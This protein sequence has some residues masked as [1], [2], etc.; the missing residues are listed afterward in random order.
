MLTS[1]HT[2]T[3][4]FCCLQR[5]EHEASYWY[6]KKKTLTCPKYSWVTS[7]MVV[8]RVWKIENQKCLFS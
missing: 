4:L 2:E 8:V 5:D 3:D 7:H 1:I 6:L